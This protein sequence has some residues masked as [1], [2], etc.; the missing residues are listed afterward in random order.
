MRRC[1]L[2]I[3]DKTILH[4]KLAFVPGRRSLGLL[5]FAKNIAV[6]AAVA[7]SI[8][9]LTPRHASAS[10]FSVPLTPNPQNCRVGGRSIHTTTALYGG[11]EGQEDG[12]GGLN[13]D[14][15]ALYPQ[16]ELLSSGSVPVSE[17]HT[18]YYEEYGNPNGKPVL[19]VHGGPGGGTSPENARYFDP[20]VY[21][22]ILVDQ[23]GCG[24][25]T[26]FAELRDNT[27]WDLVNDFE[28]LRKR[29]QI[30]KWMVFGGSWGS[31][32]GLTYAISHPERTTEL[33][34]RGIFLLRQPELDFFY[35]GKGT[36]YLF[37]SE[38]NEF[39]AE[40]PAEELEDAGGSYIL[41]YG[42]RLRGELGDEKMKSAAKSWS[43]W[44]GSTSR[45]IPPTK[46]SILSKW[47]GDEFSLAF[48]RIENHYF[49]GGMGMSG[50]N[51]SRGIP[52]FFPR[53]GWLLEDEQLA[54]IS[55]V[56]TVIV[57]GRYDV[58]CPAMSAHDLHSKLPNSILHVVTTGHSSFEP[59]IIEKLVDATDLFGGKT[60]SSEE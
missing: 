58:V 22:V 12:L 31:T 13:F 21:R 11:A 17:L 32:L 14:D 57:Q 52:G 8:P 24:K 1:V 37:P 33:V 47:A 16:P 50:S 35:E 40:I 28:T 6:V 10:A 44:E 43:V 23:R 54:K 45:L 20:A 18:L 4:D 2:K 55:D 56:P 39:A 53:E 48:A 38:W 7:S 19:F 30:E 51:D 15:T 26:P 36:N 3:A 49:T 9:Q 60:K 29:L 27:T 42:K 34:L 59:D 46:E 5:P 25:S 41:A